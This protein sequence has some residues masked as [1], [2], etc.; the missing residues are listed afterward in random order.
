[1]ARVRELEVEA[2]ANTRSLED[3][4]ELLRMFT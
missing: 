1:M 4:D 2:Q 3:C